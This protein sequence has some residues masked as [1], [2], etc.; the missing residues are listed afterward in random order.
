[1]K[2]SVV[3]PC[4]NEEKNIE[5]FFVETKKALKNLLFDF[6]LIFVN[7]GSTDGTMDI[8][9]KLCNTDETNIKIINFSRNFGKESAIYA[10]IQ[11]STGDYVTL[12]DADLQQDPKIIIEMVN[13]LEKEKDYDCVTAFQTQRKENKFIISCKNIFY[14][15]INK[16]ADVNF[17]KNASDFRTFKRSMANAIISMTEYH[18]FSKGIFSWVGFNTKY[19]PYEVRD[20]ESGETKWGFRKLLKYAFE[21]MVAFTTMPLRIATYFGIGFSVFAAI[22]LILTIIKKLFFGIDVP[23]YATIVS[24]ILFFSGIQLLCIGIIGEYLAKIYLQVKNRPIYIVKEMVTNEK[25]TLEWTT[26]FEKK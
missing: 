14:K 12:I 4:Y 13:V 3:V 22:W 10:G 23:G 16:F 18:R 9:K 5:P 20:R 19:I 21:G 6:E 26:N 25:E 17:F 2:L 1:M 8:L 7:D 15:L 11:K 24:L